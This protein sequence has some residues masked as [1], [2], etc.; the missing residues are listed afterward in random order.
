MGP[1]ESSA[2]FAFLLEK[3]EWW[4]GNKVKNLGK[5][6][7]RGVPLPEDA[8]HIM[9]WYFHLAK[10]TSSA[11]EIFARELFE[12]KARP[13][14]LKSGF[15]LKTASTIVDK[16]NRTGVQLSAMWDFAGARLTANVLHDDLRSLSR[17][18]RSHLDS[19]GI[20]TDERDYTDNPQSG[21]RAIHVLITGAAGNVELQLRT[22]FQSEW[23]NAY[24]L[25]ADKTGR[26]VR[27]ES[28]FRPDDPTLYKIKD[29]LLFISENIHRMELQQA[30]I[31]ENSEITLRNLALSLGVPISP[32]FHLLRADA[33]KNL[34]AAEIGASRQATASLELLQS[35]RNLKASIQTL[36]VGEEKTQ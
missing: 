31:I 2:D 35:L 30:R 28:D 24:E 20:G 3:P 6:L 1:K 36:E 9:G 27:Y 34:R 13:T 11:V 25:L 7:K 32:E 8:E 15:R 21:Y 12:V 17:E 29:D 22:L 14:Y 23:A 33:L 26:K 18:L 4:S 16:I 10:E 5:T 19:L